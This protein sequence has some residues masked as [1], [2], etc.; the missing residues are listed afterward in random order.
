MVDLRKNTKFGF[1]LAEAMVSMFI[2]SLIFVFSVKVVGTRPAVTK[3]KYRHGYY[4][5]Y[6]YATSVKQASSGIT[7]QGQVSGGKCTFVPPKGVSQFNVFYGANLTF[8][9]GMKVYGVLEPFIDGEIMI[10]PPLEI[11][12][13]PKVVLK[14]G[15]Q[16]LTFRITEN[17]VYEGDA[18]EPSNE[19]SF[20]EYDD[21]QRYLAEVFPD[22][23]DYKK[24]G[25]V[26]Y[27]G[28]DVDN[29]VFIS[30]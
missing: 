27:F 7:E 22:F 29:F 10:T 1:S 25:L 11:D 18:T 15:D 3:L 19:Y 26:G 6:S 9:G 20:Y 13:K 4:T 17:G 28:G 16:A 2:V 5:C 14:K 23:K 24:S 12:L 8:A 30:W 21:F